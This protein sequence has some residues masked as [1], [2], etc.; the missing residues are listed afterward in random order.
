MRKTIALILVLFLFLAPSGCWDQ[1]EI[2]EIGIVTYMAVD[3]DLEKEKYLLTSCIIRPAEVAMGLEEGLPGRRGP[4]FCI[5]SMGDSIFEANKRHQ[6][7]SPRTVFHAHTVIVV[8]GEETARQGLKKVVDY[9]SREIEHRLNLWIAV[10]E[11]EGKDLCVHAQFE[12]LLSAE[13]TQI[14]L[15]QRKFSLIYDSSL[16]DVLD[17]LNSEGIEP[18]LTKLEIIEDP[19]KPEEIQDP[20]GVVEEEGKEKED[21]KREV[22][23]IRGAAYFKG[24]NLAGFLDEKETN[25]L[26]WLQGK[27]GEVTLVI[28]D[29]PGTPGRFTVDKIKGR[30]ETIPLVEGE[31]ITFLVKVKS[32]G[33]LIDYI[34]EKDFVEPEIINILEDNLSKI[35][36]DEIL[37]VANTA[38]E[39]ET[40]FLGLGRK[41]HRNNPE[42]WK[43]VKENW[44]EI[45]PQVK[46]EVEVDTAIRRIG[47]T[48][49]P[50]DYN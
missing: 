39:Q 19:L 5:T 37:T 44:E 38:Q 25:G 27:M 34:G 43:R 16:K 41:L 10:V 20:L 35:I 46:V 6:L 49:E 29:P 13:I 15:R 45:F 36:K 26:L 12:E 21:L 22:V 3:Y 7:R 24:D 14:I 33:N 31:E 17:N 47:L 28:K 48:T 11:G 8:I 42:T 4:N 2:D 32:E 30:S 1:R 40:D 23:Q 50:P 9:L 18:V